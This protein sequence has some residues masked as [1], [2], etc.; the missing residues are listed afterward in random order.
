MYYTVREAASQQQCIS[1]AVAAAPAGP[2]L[3]DSSGPLVCQRDLGGSIDPS[4][5]V[6]DDGHVRIDAAG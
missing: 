6:D 1:R 5:F 4:P 2:F 3:D